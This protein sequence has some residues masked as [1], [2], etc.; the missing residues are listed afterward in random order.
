MISAYRVLERV[1]MVS[2]TGFQFV[3]DVTGAGIKDGLEAQAFSMADPYV[4]TFAKGG[5]SG[6]CRFA[7]FP[8]VRPRVSV[9]DLLGRFL[10]LQFDGGSVESGGEVRLF[11]APQ[12]A[13]VFGLAT[14]R[15][16][17]RDADTG[18]P[19]A[20]SLLRLSRNGATWTGLSDARG[21]VVVTLPYPEPSPATVHSILG[22]TPLPLHRQ[23]WGFEVS[24]RYRRWVD[25][26]EIPSA[27]LRE[28]LAG[29]AAGHVWFDGTKTAEFPIANLEYGQELILRSRDAGGYE[30]SEL[31]ITPQG[32]INA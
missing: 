2:P 6:Y 16:F 25:P 31:L 32:G 13:P 24:V 14:A 22:G 28:D 30:M 12:R 9:T 11:S 1:K 19:G 26:A 21:S 10:P 29:L 5:G 18:L 23:H 15:A 7:R 17:L 27:P 20:W 4:R 3:D 8:Q